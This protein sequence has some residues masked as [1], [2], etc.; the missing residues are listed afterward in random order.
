MP[1]RPLKHNRPT[2][3]VVAGW[4]AYDGTMSS[5][6]SP[7]LHGIQTAAHERNCNLLFACGIGNRRDLSN[8]IRPAW[9]DPMPSADF[10]PVGPWNTDGLVVVM[11]LIVEARSKYIQQL[12]A[13]GHPVVFMAP[14]ETG[15]KIAIDNQGGIHQAVRHLVEHGHRRIAFISGYNTIYNANS[16]DS[17]QR[18]AA[19]HAAMQHYGLPVTPRLIAHLGDNISG[20]HTAMQTIL[21]S[22]EPFTAVVAFNDEAAIGAMQALRENGRRIPED[23]AVIGFDNRIEASAQIPPLTSVHQPLS[24]MGYQAFNLLVQLIDGQLNNPELIRVP[25]RLVVRQSCGCQ[26]GHAFTEAAMTPAPSPNQPQDVLR[27]LTQSMRTAL[28]ASG[29]WLDPVLVYALCERLIDAFLESAKRADPAHFQSLFI[30]ALQ[31]IEWADGDTHDWQAVISVLHQNLPL[32]QQAGLLKTNTKIAE[33]ILHQA[34]I[35]VSESVQWRYGRYVG[36]LDE[37]MYQLGQLSARLYTTVEDAKIFEVLSEVLPGFG[38]KQA[39]LAFFEPEGDDPLA[40]SRLHNLVGAASPTAKPIR[41]AT[42]DF[43]PQNLYAADEP[44]QVGLLPLNV[45]DGVAGYMVFDADTLGPCAAIVRQVEASMQSAELYQQAAEGRR[46]AE[47]ANSLK[48]SFLSM[49]SHELRTPLNLIV[50]LSEMLMRAPGTRQPTLP[51]TFSSDLQRIHDSAQHLGRLIRDVLDMASSEAGQLRLESEAINLLDDLY[52]VAEVGEQ[53]ARDKG[54]QWRTAIPDSLP[55]VWGDRTRLRQVML[56]LI[57]N[58]VKFTPQGYVALEAEAYEGQITISVR[59]T[60]L[61]VPLEEQPLLFNEFRQSERTRARNYGGMGLGLAICKRLVE[62]HGGEAGVDSPGPDEGGSTFYFRLPE[63]ISAEAQPAAIETPQ[64]Q[65]AQV[66]ILSEHGAAAGRLQEYLQGQGFETAVLTVVNKP[67]WATSLVE[68]PP[69]A[70]V[71]DLGSASDL[72]WEVLRLLKSRPATQDIPVLFYS[73][74]SEQNSGA[75]LEMD[76]LAKPVGMAELAQALARQGLLNGGEE[77]VILVVDDEPGTLEMNVRMVQAQSSTYRVLKAHNGREALEILKH[78]P[79]DLALL[80]LM[81][82]EMDGFE[83]LEVMRSAPDT[84][85]IPVIVLTAKLLTEVDMVRLN[86]GVAT[87]LEKGMFSV[88]EMLGH[89][90]EV[91]ALNRKLGSEAGR[92]VRKAM[93][94]LHEHYAEPLTREKIARHVG[95]S[96]DYLTHCFQQE[97]HM[98]P[99]TYLTRY[100]LNHAKTLLAAGEMSVAGVAETVGFSGEVYF[101]RV[102]KREVGVAPGAYRRGQRA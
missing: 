10:V 86:R 31:R 94:Y 89:I 50:G 91:L 51:F 64:T 56:N 96:E 69:G 84:R 38:I 102:F 24:E 72:G 101:S 68:T 87:V 40:R 100:R 30:M 85:D 35:I 3:G 82:P 39:Q 76:Y 8:E 79:V 93:A 25:T 74:A 12:Q 1:T 29:K 73:I 45:R 6:M 4:Q 80:D 65:S 32:L 70:V 92:L 13:A 98:P 26:P 57:S 37:M 11:P 71:L 97:L 55:L 62:L 66:L 47:E 36:N 9:P 44:F 2:I 17:E 61:G 81:M 27:W 60:G 53:L 21:E 83:V 90:E 22:H 99:M 15:P 59:D 20:G 75:V 54:L 34:R 42:R 95:V 18:L 88:E 48:S 77:K 63:W 28:P 46:L 7:V 43:P 67:D 16:S 14:G 78:R 41:F 49:V 58:A 5:F 23:V 33:A 19:Y 52:A